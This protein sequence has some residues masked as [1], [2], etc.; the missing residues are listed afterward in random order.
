[1]PHHPHFRL[2]LV[3]TALAW[4]AS[5]A[6]S[7]LTIG[8]LQGTTHRSSFANTAVSNIGGVVTA[9]DGNGFW[10]QDADRKSVV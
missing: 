8:D 2:N 10:M 3:V 7:A 1:M 9:I 6:A 4:A 5:G